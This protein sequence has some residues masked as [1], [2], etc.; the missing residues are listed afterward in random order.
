MLDS[1][2]RIGERAIVFGQGVLGLLTLALLSQFPLG[3]VIA[4]DPIA[5][6]RALSQTWGAALTVDPFDCVQT[7]ELKR[8]L[9]RNGDGVDFA[10][11][12]SG[13]M[14]A[15]NQAVELVGFAG[16]IV[17]GSWYGRSTAALD[18]G[19]VL[20]P[21]NHTDLEPGQHRSA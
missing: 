18:L 14:E 2:P 9:F 21:Q 16:R 15:L 17:I 12:V 5:Y 13:R 20:P 11:E 8:G 19:G 7:L 6:R 10:I 4:A 1:R 3:Q